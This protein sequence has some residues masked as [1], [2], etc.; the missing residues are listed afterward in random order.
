MLSSMLAAPAGSRGAPLPDCPLLTASLPRPGAAEQAAR[1]VE[2]GSLGSLPV[3]Q[4]LAASRL[5]QYLGQCDQ[6]WAEAADMATVVMQALWGVRPA[7]ALRKRLERQSWVP[8]LPPAAATSGKQHGG[9]PR[10]SNTSAERPQRQ[11]QQQLQRDLQQ[12]CGVGGQAALDAVWVACCT[13]RLAAVGRMDAPSQA[14]AETA[15]C[16][17]QALLDCCADP[18]AVARHLSSAAQAVRLA[19]GGCR[20]WGL[21]WRRRQAMLALLH[22]ALARADAQQCECCC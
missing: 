18:A 17:A 2:E 19:F 16:D 4:L 10:A 6:S 8:Q 9:A 21:D 12:H 7:R 5:Q 13:L 3:L 11:A 1:A 14:H 22:E 15:L 20:Y